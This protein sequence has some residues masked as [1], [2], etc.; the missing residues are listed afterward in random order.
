MPTYYKRDVTGTTNWNLATSWSTVSSTSSVNST[1]SFPSSTTLDPVIFDANSSACTVN[2]AA[3]CTS[4]TFT[5]YAN[6]ITMTNGITVSGNVTLANTATYVGPSGITMNAATSTITFAGATYNLPLTVSRAFNT[7]AST[8][9]FADSGQVSN[10]TVTNGGGTTTIT[11][12]GSTSTLSV[13]G[14]LIS[15]GIGMAGASNISIVLNGSGNLSGTITTN[16]TFNTSGTITLTGALLYYSTALGGTRTILYQNGTINW[17][18]F[19]LA[20]YSINGATL[21]INFP[22]PI[23]SVL[24]QSQV[25]VTATNTLQSDLNVT[26]FTSSIISGGSGAGFVVIN[27]FNIYVSGNFSVPNQTCSGTTKIWITGT[28]TINTLVAIGNNFEINSPSGTVTLQTLIF[29]GNITFTYTAAFAFIQT[30]NLQFNANATYTF[31]NPGNANFGQL[32][33]YV[34]TNNNNCIVNFNHDVNCTGILF[35]AAGGV[36]TTLNGNTINV[37]GN[38]TRSNFPTVGGTSTIRFT[39]GVGTATWAGLSY[40]CNFII[41]KSVSFT[42]NMTFTTS[43]RS[44]VVTGTG[45]VNPNTTSVTVSTNVSMTISNMTFW[46]LTIG[47]SATITQN[48]LNT[49]NSILLLSGNA[50]FTGTAGWT[51][52]SFTHGG[53]GTTCTLKAGVTYTVLQGGIFT[54]IGT[55]ASRAILQSDDVVAVT[56]SIPANSN[57]MTLTATVPNPIGYVLGS[58]AFSTAL[59][60]AL[61]NILPDRPTIVSGPVGLDYTLANNIGPTAL[62]SYAGQL[63]KKAFFNVFGTTNVVYAATRDIDSTGGITIYAGQSFPDNTATPNQFRTLNWQPLIAPSGSV[64]YTWV[65]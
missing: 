57:Q 42:E 29:Q 2:V 24:F 58:T 49:I 20:F 62:T 44:V 59:P 19:S 38:V 10:F 45:S 16:L 11:L 40:G 23:F 33:F 52:F 56:A 12:S 63:G 35:S 30:G 64:Y 46:N 31:N 61:S 14:N 32:V 25:S 7:G 28:G 65:D 26:N 1:N 41:N 17:N 8:F 9:T 36:G 5:G 22:Y 4:I 21:N 43:G 37:S 27:G 54:M 18:G 60:A 47:T 15:S 13:S 6:T 34:F 50:T 48:T 3:T 53:A 39:G 55:A 51:A